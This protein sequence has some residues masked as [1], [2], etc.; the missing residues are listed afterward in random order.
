M[1]TEDT[2][3]VRLPREFPLARLAMIA[4]EHGYS[5]RW[6]QHN[7]SNTTMRTPR[8]LEIAPFFQCNQPEAPETGAG[9]TA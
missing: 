7:D 3:L 2:Y 8:I 1:N 9:E 6:S 5:Y 4:A